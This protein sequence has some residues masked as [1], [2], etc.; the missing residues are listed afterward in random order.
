MRLET[1]AVYRAK[2]K[3]L[4]TCLVLIYGCTI[5]SQTSLLENSNNAVHIILKPC[6]LLDYSLIVVYIRFSTLSLKIFSWSVELY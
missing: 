6:A 4:A 3:V 5:F 1:T 2:S